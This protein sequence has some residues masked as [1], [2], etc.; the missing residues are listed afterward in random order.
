MRT[1]LT[2]AI[3]STLLVGGCAKDDVVTTL[4]A[5]APSTATA[6][7][8]PTPASEDREK[9]P[10]RLLG[11][12]GT[13]GDLGGPNA[14]PRS[15]SI[16][17]PDEAWVCSYGAKDDDPDGDGAT[18]Y[19][20]IR[21]GDIHPVASS[22][23]PDIVASLGQLVPVPDDRACRLDLGTRWLL[24][25][26]RDGEL[27]GVTVDDFGCGDVLMTDDPFTSV[28]G[29]ARQKGTVGGA[30]NAPPSLLTQLESVAGSS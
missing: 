22:D 26:E 6:T 29:D 7:A 12:G 9:C 11:P 1:L 18:T 20:W 8:A 30:L 21:F 3:V 10:E 17:T 4:P 16:A 5:P 25:L 14:A 19:S 28:P 27:T 15:P 2:I 24:V 23:L 13:T